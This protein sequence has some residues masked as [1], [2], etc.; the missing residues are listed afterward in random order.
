MSQDDRI[1]RL[2]AA[3]LEAA[4]NGLKALLLLNG[5]ASIAILAFLAQA[6]GKDGVASE[7]S[8][9]VQE[10]VRSLALFAA[11]AGVAVLAMFFAYYSNQSY[12]ASL[13]A[14][15]KVGWKRGAL[16]NV[17]G[18]AIAAISLVLF[19]VGVYRIWVAADY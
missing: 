18:G 10:M 14:P 15:E 12:A 17:G 4:T 6:L 16:L 8:L 19:W 13:M 5:G 11:G 7:Y 2:E 9:L 3:S 1:A